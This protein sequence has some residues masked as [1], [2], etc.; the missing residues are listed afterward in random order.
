MHLVRAAVFA[1]LLEESVLVVL[2]FLLNTLKGHGEGGEGVLG[3]RNFAVFVGSLGKAL[4]LV[5][6]ALWVDNFED[7]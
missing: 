2:N 6:K 7:L 3:G 5:V 1:S 4:F